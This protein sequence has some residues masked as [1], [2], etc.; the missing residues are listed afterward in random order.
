MVEMR[1]DSD[2][3]IVYRSILKIN[4]PGKNVISLTE[5]IYRILGCLFVISRQHDD[6]AILI[7]QFCRL[8]VCQ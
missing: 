3:R 6:S 2:S 1:P 5:V 7:Y 8:S 4:I